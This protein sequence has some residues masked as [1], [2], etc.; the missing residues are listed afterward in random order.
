MLDI[1]QGQGVIGYVTRTIWAP[2]G[3]ERRKMQDN[4]GMSMQHDVFP[5]PFLTDDAG[6]RISRWSFILG[7]KV[8]SPRLVAGLWAEWEHL[9]YTQ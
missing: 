8:P 5:L 2:R 9:N 7:P 4:L 1:C 3:V 6:W